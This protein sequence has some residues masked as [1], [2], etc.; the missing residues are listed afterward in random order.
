MSLTGERGARTDGRATTQHHCQVSGDSFELKHHSPKE[1]MDKDRHRVKLDEKEEEDRKRSKRD[2]VL[3]QGKK[4]LPC[5][6]ITCY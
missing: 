6:G 4:R 2:K 1:E 5:P 3:A